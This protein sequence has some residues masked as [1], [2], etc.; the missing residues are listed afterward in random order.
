MKYFTQVIGDDSDATEREYT[1]ARRDGK[2]F[3]TTGDRI[4]TTDSAGAARIWGASG[5]A[6]LLPVGD[7]PLVTW[8]A[9]ETRANAG[10]FEPGGSLLT[11]GND[12]QV[13]RYHSAELVDEVVLDAVRLAEQNGLENGLEIHEIAFRGETYE[14]L[15]AAHFG[16]GAVPEDVHGDGDGTSVVDAV[17]SVA[18]LLHDPA[19]PGD[20]ECDQGSVGQEP[21]HHVRDQRCSHLP[22]DLRG[23]DLPTRHVPSAHRFD[24]ED[25]RGVSARAF[26]F[27]RP[28]GY[29][30][31]QTITL[32]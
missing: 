29:S 3:A 30:F 19:P 27:S 28:I 12:G 24:G 1:F 23:H 6:G 4:L 14:L 5:E 9:H 13:R 31:R 11:V 7:E 21:R 22:G 18:R 32:A 25:G 26:D 16:V 17:G 15:A 20:C 8:Q 10:V 2:L